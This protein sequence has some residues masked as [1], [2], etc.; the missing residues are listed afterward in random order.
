MGNVNWLALVSSAVGASSLIFIAKGDVL[1]QFLVLIG[2]IL[3]A[4]VSYIQSYYGELAIS[5]LLVAPIAAASIVSWIRHKYNGK[6]REVEIGKVSKKGM[7]VILASAAAVSAGFYFLLKAVGTGELVVSTVSVATSFTA[8][9]LLVKRSPLYAFAYILND[10]VLITLW[11]LS[12]VK[13][14]SYLPM[15]VCFGVYLLNDLYG[16]INW[17]RMRNRQQKEKAARE[18]AA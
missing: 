6:A 1:G 15:A 12:T 3:Y 16:L 13:N 2:S 5:A 11:T 14:L 7:A 18:N 9:C 8:S 17:R 10:F 4:A